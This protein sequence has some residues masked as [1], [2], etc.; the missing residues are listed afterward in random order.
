MKLIIS[1]EYIKNLIEDIKQI[2]I[3]YLINI[4]D[5]NKYLNLKNGIE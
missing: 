5:E 3:D 4:C 2:Q 1:Y